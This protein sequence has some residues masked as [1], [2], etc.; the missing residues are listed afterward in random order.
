[1]ASAAW[2]RRNALARARGY[3]NYYDYRAHGYGTRETK[4]SGEQLRQ[5]RG[6]A[7]GSDLLTWAKPGGAT[8]SRITGRDAQGRRTKVEVQYIDERGMRSFTLRGRQV[9][10]DYLDMLYDAM[11][12]ADVD[13]ET[14]LG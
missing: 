14:Y 4:A 10:Q 11:A 7:S 2:E 6:H 9:D 12:D 1:M 8:V 5:L 13:V 3:E